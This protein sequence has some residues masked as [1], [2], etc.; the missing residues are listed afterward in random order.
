MYLSGLCFGVY[1]KA[2]HSKTGLI[3]PYLTFLYTSFEKIFCQNLVKK[4]RK[5][6][7]MFSYENADIWCEKGYEKGARR[8]CRL[9]F[10]SGN[11]GLLLLENRISL[12]CVRLFGDDDVDLLLRQY[13]VIVITTYMYYCISP[14][15][16][17]FITSPLVRSFSFIILLFIDKTNLHRISVYPYLSAEFTVRNARAGRRQKEYAP[18]RCYG[19]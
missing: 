15:P 3:M 10:D 9:F 5:L 17:L 14:V 11:V 13:G 4:N 1:R 6:I 7:L 12:L 2:I 8:M 16:S 19:W 18:R